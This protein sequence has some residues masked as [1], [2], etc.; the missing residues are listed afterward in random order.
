M[1]YAHYIDL[2]PYVQK[3]LPE[4]VV[5]SPKYTENHTP[6]STCLYKMYKKL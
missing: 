1:I 3:V 2:G 4:N 5:T 6:N